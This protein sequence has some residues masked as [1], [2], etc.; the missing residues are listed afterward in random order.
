MT[1]VLEARNLSLGY[2]GGEWLYRHLNFSLRQGE[3]LGVAGPSGCGKSTLCLALSGIIPHSVQAQMEGEVFLLGEN[4]R[5]LSLPQ[6]ATRAGI[7]FQ[8]PETQLFL[9]QIRHELAF[10]PENLCR[11]REEI[12]ATIGKVASL[13]AIEG[14]LPH[15]PNEISGGQR[16]LAALAAVLCLDP[17]VLILDEVA[18]QLDEESSARILEVI[19]LLKE[20]GKT[21]VM[22][23]HNLNRLRLADWILTLNG[24]R[25][26]RLEPGELF[27]QD[28][29]AP[30]RCFG[31]FSG[32][33][34]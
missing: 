10:G 17:A 3:M 24:D 2:P 30:E 9:P 18:S 14:L 21:I 13:T 29:N 15:N 31:S 28:P 12:A 6:I 7:V 25:T 8:D 16:Q 20:E 22:V 32:E 11:P 5:S 26:G 4:T 33:V 27:F 34:R 1:V 19:R 23:D